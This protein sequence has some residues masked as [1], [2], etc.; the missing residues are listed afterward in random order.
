M[1]RTIRALATAVLALCVTVN[2]AG[3]QQPSPV[4]GEVTKVDQ[5]A[6]KI[7]IRHGPIKNLDMNE[8]SMTMVFAVQDPTIM[9]NLKPGDKIKFAAERVNGIITVT[10]IQK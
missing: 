6:N 5:S 8:K 1:L 3:T 4:A 9:Q 2:L 7:T 10:R